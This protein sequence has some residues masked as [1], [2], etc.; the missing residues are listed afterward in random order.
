M[1]ICNKM[2][3]KCQLCWSSILQYKIK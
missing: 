1:L 2:W 3:K